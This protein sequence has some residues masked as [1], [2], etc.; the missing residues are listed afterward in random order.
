MNQTLRHP[1]VA[2]ISS[3]LALAFAIAMLVPSAGFAASG[4]DHA[5]EARGPVRTASSVCEAQR[6]K[7]A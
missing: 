2:G 7:A 5:E 6:L 4:G 3:A 1:L